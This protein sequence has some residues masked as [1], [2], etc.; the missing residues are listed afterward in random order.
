[1]AEGEPR[2][3][4]DVQLG[5]GASLVVHGDT[6]GASEELSLGGI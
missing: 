1:V 6:T 3:D 5:G 2:T 4:H